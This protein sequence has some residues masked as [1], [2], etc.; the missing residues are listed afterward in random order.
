MHRTNVYLTT[1]EERALD[2]RARAEG[3]TRSKVLRNIIDAALGLGDSENR[4]EVDAL[5]VQRAGLIAGE[6]R[7]LAARDP[8]LRSA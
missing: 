2:A 7:R 4:D 3:A 8:D 1:E 6:A 5:L